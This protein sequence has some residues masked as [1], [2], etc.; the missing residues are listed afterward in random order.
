MIYKYEENN[1]KSTQ[2][3]LLKNIDR[4]SNL[5]EIQEYIRSVISIR[6]FE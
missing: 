6:G 1:K 2:E 3:G 5:D 4:T